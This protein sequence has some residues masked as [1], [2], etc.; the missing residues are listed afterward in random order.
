[1]VEFF[2]CLFVFLNYAK[3]CTRLFK[4]GLYS[5]DIY[6]FIFKV[7]VQLEKVNNGLLKFHDF[8]FSQWLEIKWLSR[9]HEFG[10]SNY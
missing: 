8:D 1:M 5:N 6:I 10:R 3:T 2:V 7:Q 9:T 4:L